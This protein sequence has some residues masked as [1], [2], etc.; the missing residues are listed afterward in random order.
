VDSS[1][2]LD[3]A[4]IQDPTPFFA[5][6]RERHP[7]WRVPATTLL[8]VS[9]WDLVFDAV[10]R[11]ADFS[12][13]LRS[14]VHRGPDGAPALFDMT[15]LGSN[16]ETLATADPPAHTT[17]RRAVFPSLVERRMQA[18]EGVARAV[19]ADL[20]GRFPASGP[21]DAVGAFSDLLPMTV[22]VEVLGITGTA[23]VSDLLAWAFDGTALLAG[24]NSLE[25]MGEL[26]ERAA[27]AGR[28]LGEC[29]ATAP[30][31][32]EAGIVGAT[33]RAV[34]DGELTPEE[35]VATL[36]ILLGAGGESTTSLIGSSLRRLAEDPVLQDRL[37]R[38]PTLVPP[39]VE[40]VLRLETPFKGHFRHVRQDTTLGD[41]TVHEGDTL[42]LCWGSA[43]RDGHRF[44]DPDALRLDRPNPRE[45]LG[46]GRGVHHCVGAP[47]ARMEARI[48]I[49][50]ILARTEGVVIDP[51]RPPHYV[52]SMFVRRLER[53]DLVAR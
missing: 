44:D 35:G 12:S 38:D 39:F 40:E 4:V 24:T 16:I 22:L 52:D 28:F 43:N 41:T 6:L 29:L 46:F 33:A 53:L 26:T 32:P 3:P 8:L 7:V 49:E 15:P 50:E 42:F 1:A 9:T 18:V 2:L 23:T 25:R 13:N 36:T 11:T 31:D 21:V 47:L 37:R 30:P 48:A 19:A 17:H 5:Q 45:H 14:L 34:A 27:Q 20:I 51:T 10:G